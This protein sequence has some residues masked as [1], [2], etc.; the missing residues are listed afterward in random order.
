MAI[1]PYLLAELSESVWIYNGF[2]TWSSISQL[3]SE[4]ITITCLLFFFIW[5]SYKQSP[6]CKS[7]RSTALGCRYN[8]QTLSISLCLAPTPMSNFCTPPYISFI[9]LLC[10]YYS[11]IKGYYEEEK[12]K[13]PMVFFTNICFCQKLQMLHYKC[14]VI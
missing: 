13:N 8:E 3:T 9:I 5:F 4:T 7:K 10:Y 12:Q 11:I 6:Q 2:T 1:D 14:V